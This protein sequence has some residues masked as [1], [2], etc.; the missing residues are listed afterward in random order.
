MEPNTSKLA[1]V[2]L[3]LAALGTL[4]SLLLSIALGLK[5]CPLCFYQRTFVLAVLLLGLLVDR[6]HARLFCLLSLPMA[7]AGLGVAAFHQYLVTSGKL[8]CPSG[9]LG[10]GTAPLQSLVLFIALSVVVA[11]GIGRRLVPALGAAAIGVALAV[12]C[13]A[14]APSMPPAPPEPYSDPLEICRPP[15]RPQA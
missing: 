5:A 8:E 7:V 13:I 4:G 11:L 12:V 9:L 3:A 1:Y 15:Y 14:S 10:M 6:Q 2:A